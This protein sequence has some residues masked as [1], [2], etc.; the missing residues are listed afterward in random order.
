MKAISKRQHDKSNKRIILYTVESP[1]VMILL[2]E[3]GVF[4]NFLDECY[5]EFFRLLNDAKNRRKLLT[6]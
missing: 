5:N 1:N 3:F 6:H 2:S 4:I